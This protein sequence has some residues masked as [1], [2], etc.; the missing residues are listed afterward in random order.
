MKETML[1]EVAD[2][3]ARL[4]MMD[5]SSYLVNPSD[6]PTS[7]TWV[8]TTNVVIRIVSDDMFDSD[9]HNV[10]DDVKVLAMDQGAD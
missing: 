1:S 6:V 10:D 2:D 5:G 9:I 7:I 4:I 3:G 8:P